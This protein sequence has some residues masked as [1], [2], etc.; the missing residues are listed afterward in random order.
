MQ[1]ASWQQ[2]SLDLLYSDGFGVG[3]SW[4]GLAM[5]WVGLASSPFF[6]LPGLLSMGLEFVYLSLALW[7]SIMDCEFISIMGLCFI[8]ILLAFGLSLKKLSLFANFGLVMDI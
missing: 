4:Y 1:G 8:S 2:W 3:N 5:G 7:L 6:L